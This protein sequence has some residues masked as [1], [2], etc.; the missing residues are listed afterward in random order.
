LLGLLIVRALPDEELRARL[1]SPV[2]LVVCREAAA[3]L[4]CGLAE[5]ADPLL[6]LPD[7]SRHHKPGRIP[8]PGR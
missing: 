8:P 5:A 6:G 3:R 4:R 2:A 1:P 7:A